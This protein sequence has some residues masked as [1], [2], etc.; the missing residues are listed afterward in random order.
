MH[1]ITKKRKIS[2]K[3]KSLEGTIN[4]V[5]SFERPKLHTIELKPNITQIKFFPKQNHKRQ[6]NI[7][8]KNQIITRQH[9]LNS[10]LKRHYKEPY[11]FAISIKF[12]RLP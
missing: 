7:A 12:K 1:K 9:F 2:N 11:K 5:I 3:S 8:R 6:E 10:T 4:Q